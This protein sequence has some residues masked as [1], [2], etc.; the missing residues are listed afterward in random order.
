MCIAVIVKSSVLL[1]AL[2]WSLGIGQQPTPTQPSQRSTSGIVEAV[3]G[4][5]DLKPARFAHVVA[6]PAGI[7]GDFKSA[8]GSMSKAIDDLRAGPKG[9]K[10]PYP[11]EIEL[12]CVKA[13]IKVEQSLAIL[14]KS[15]KDDPDKGVILADAD[16]LGEFNLSGL[17][18]GAYTVV[19]T[20]KV[21]LN[22]AFWLVELEP[23][24]QSKR[25]KMTRPQ[26]ACYDPD[27]L[28]KP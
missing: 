10:Y 18:D 7:A 2:I 4:N 17:G 11:E 23:S 16:E 13:L 28:F 22:G 27:G 24:G 1:S 12:Q 25:I 19:A 26:F 15:A 5:G 6:V 21:G 8:V 9:G 3:I 20:G 14:R